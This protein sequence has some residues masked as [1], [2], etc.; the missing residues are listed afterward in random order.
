MVYFLGDFWLKFLFII[1]FLHAH[2]MLHMSHFSWLFHPSRICCILQ[3][4]KYKIMHFVYS[5]VSFSI[6]SWE[7]PLRTLFSNTLRAWASCVLKQKFPS[8][9]NTRVHKWINT[10]GENMCGN[11]ETEIIQTMIIKW[12]EPNNE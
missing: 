4:I 12:L 7:V 2:F 10:T 8:I 11:N 1:R 5:T 9:K 6:L 3:I